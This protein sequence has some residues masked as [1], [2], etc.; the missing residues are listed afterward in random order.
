MSALRH[1]Y[2]YAARP[3]RTRAFA[4]ANARVSGH[5][6][7]YACCPMVGRQKLRPRNGGRGR[8]GG[9]TPGHLARL[10]CNRRC[11]CTYVRPWLYGGWHATGVCRARQ[12]IKPTSKRCRPTAPYPALT[13]L[14]PLLAVP[15]TIYT[16]ICHAPSPL[17]EADLYFGHVTI[18]S[19]QNL[20]LRVF[21]LVL[22]N[23]SDLFRFDIFDLNFLILKII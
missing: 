14:S 4:Y 6:W 16:G 5:V 2:D 22:F 20:F 3:A 1:V 21:S 10:D 18:P 7:I 13:S 8:G 15:W 12:L 9:H 23:L 11:I 17:G 19:L